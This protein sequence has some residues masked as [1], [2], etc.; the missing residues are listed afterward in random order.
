M[1]RGESLVNSCR[2]YSVNSIMLFL[3]LT[4]SYSMAGYYYNLESDAE[5]RAFFPR[6]A[7]RA[8]NMGL[9]GFGSVNKRKLVGIQNQSTHIR[10]TVLAGIVE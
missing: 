8:Q 1:T 7:G 4:S 10:Q 9:I 5:M 3:L 6:C 2:C